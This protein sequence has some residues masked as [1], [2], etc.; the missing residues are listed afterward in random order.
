[1]IT[2]KEAKRLINNYNVSISRKLLVEFLK[3]Y[4]VFWKQLKNTKV[5]EESYLHVKK[6]VNSLEEQ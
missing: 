5:T 2:I 4:P 6:F 1:M 3:Q